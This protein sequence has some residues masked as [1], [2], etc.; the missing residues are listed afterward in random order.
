MRSVKLS[1]SRSSIALVLTFTLSACS[2]PEILHSASS[3]CLN[4]R[5]LSVSVPD[6]PEMDDPGNERD[7]FDTTMAIFAHNAV[8]HKICKG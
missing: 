2:Q 3:F 5:P 6:G 4:D 1:K 8:Y 7:T